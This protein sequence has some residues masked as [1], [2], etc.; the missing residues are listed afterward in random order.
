VEIP[1]YRG[2][3][4]AQIDIGRGD[5]EHGQSARR[6]ALIAGDVEAAIAKGALW[7]LRVRV[8]L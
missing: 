1:I 8:I 3:Q 6:N 7:S 4:N 2:T 5:G